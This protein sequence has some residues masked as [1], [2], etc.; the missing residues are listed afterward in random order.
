MFTSFSMVHG[1]Y[2][3]VKAPKI[4][5]KEVGAQAEATTKIAIFA[6]FLLG[7]GLVVYTL[8]GHGISSNISEKIFD[9]GLANAIIAIPL[10]AAIFAKYYYSRK[11][12]KEIE[13]QS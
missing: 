6:D 12:R 11:D 9:F 8:V 5:Q 1:V 10:G 3:V 7:A 2:S 4:D 13:G